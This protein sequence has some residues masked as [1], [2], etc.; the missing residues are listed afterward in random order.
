MY[1]Q[2]SLDQYCLRAMKIE[3]IAHIFASK[4]DN[5]TYRPCP[6]T[7]FQLKLPTLASTLS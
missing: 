1:C 5:L 3:V 6:L 4:G 7:L 2:L